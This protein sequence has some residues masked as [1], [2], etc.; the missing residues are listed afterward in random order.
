MPKRSGNGG[1]LVT[2][3]EKGKCPGEIQPVE[4]TVIFKKFYLDAGEMHCQIPGGD[5]GEAA[6]QPGAELNAHIFTR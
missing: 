4:I 2:D 1:F 3:S 6:R 5:R